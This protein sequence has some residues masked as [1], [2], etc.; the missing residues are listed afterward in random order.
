MTATEKIDEYI[1]KHNDWRGDLL[2]K[3]RQLV[4]ETAPQVEEDWK[5]SSP[6]FFRKRKND[7]Q[8]KCF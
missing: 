6:I 1:A 5:W 8:P 7:L 3:I 2:S 4:H